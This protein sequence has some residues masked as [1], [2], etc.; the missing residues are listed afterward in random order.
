MDK[1]EITGSSLQ[2][3]LQEA[4]ARLK[5]TPDRIR[6][7]IDTEKTR[8]FGHKQREITIRA[9]VVSG[10]IGQEVVAYLE[11]LFGLMGLELQVEASGFE[12]HQKVLLRGRDYKLLLYQNGSLLN[13]LQYL[14]NRVFSDALGSKIY[15]ECQNFRKNREKELVAL[16]HSSSKQVIKKGQEVHLGEL[17]P[18]ERRIVHMT[19]NQYPQLESSSE[20]DSFLKVITIRKKQ[21]V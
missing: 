19:V 6:Y 9:W 4:G 10:D 5:A 2:E 18:F 12:T 15:C 11:H 14:L 13:A 20:G 1:L 7:E 16:A 3:V 21:D 8:Y 17:N